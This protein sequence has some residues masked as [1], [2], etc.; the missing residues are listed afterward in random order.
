MIVISCSIAQSIA[1]AF[2]MNVSG[3]PNQQIMNYARH[4]E[5]SVRVCASISV[6][7]SVSSSWLK[8][9]TLGNALDES[10]YPAGNETSWETWDLEVLP[11][12]KAGVPDRSRDGSGVRSVSVGRTSAWS[13]MSPACLQIDWSEILSRKAAGHVVLTQF[14]QLRLYRSIHLFTLWKPNTPHLLFLDLHAWLLNEI[15]CFHYCAAQKAFFR[16]FGHMPCLKHVGLF[17]LYPTRL[18]CDS[19]RHVENLEDISC[20]F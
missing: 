2:I 15:I 3:I 9:S 13:C 1:H 12:G 18:P 8:N 10:V 11:V 19:C 17:Q 14:C 16:D 6:S 20:C 4:F 7:C 5:S